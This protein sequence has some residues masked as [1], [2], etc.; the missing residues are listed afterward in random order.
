MKTGSNSAEPSNTW[1][2]RG[3]KAE[4]AATEAWGDG[5]YGELGG[6]R[7]PSATTALC[8][9]TQKSPFHKFIS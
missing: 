3:E 5:T 6:V 2:N 8:A 7:S 4:N 1:G 9:S